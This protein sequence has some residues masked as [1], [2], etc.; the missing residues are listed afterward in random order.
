MRALAA[1]V[2]VGLVSVTVSEYIHYIIF[3]SFDNALKECAQYYEVSDCDLNQYVAESYPDKPE[4]RRLVRCALINLQSWYDS[5]G[6]IESEIINFFQPSCSDD[7][8]K[9]RTQACLNSVAATVCP[10]DVNNWAYQ[11]FMCYFRYY[12]NLLSTDQ[13]LR[14]A[15]LEISQTFATAVEVLELSQDT[16]V[17]FCKG[18]ILN[19]DQ[20][21]AVLYQTSVRFGFF[22]VANGVQLMRLYNQFGNPQL[23]APET[24]QCVSKV[25]ADYCGSDDVTVVY[26][27]YVQCLANLAPIVDLIREFSKTQVSDPSVCDCTSPQI[28]VYNL[29]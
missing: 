5:T 12:G 25:A 26:Q 19:N 18:N 2:F 29:V 13:F 24:Q 22:T 23:L 16:L 14:Y 17:E 10:A 9:N 20:F 3:K 6:L 7:C 21:P 8:Y 4:V 1:I 27:T 15:P 11:S 28:Q